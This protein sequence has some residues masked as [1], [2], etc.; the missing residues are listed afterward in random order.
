MGAIMVVPLVLA[1]AAN[2]RV[3]YS[4]MRAAGAGAVIVG[5]DRNIEEVDGLRRVVPWCQLSCNPRNIAFVH[6]DADIQV[7][8]IEEYADL[9]VLSGQFAVERIG[10]PKAGAGLRR[11]PELLIQHAVHSDASVGHAC[12]D[13]GA[14]T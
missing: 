10:L 11:R 14:L 7:L 9:G 3:E 5:I 13:N 12:G 6:A 1:W 4:L 2:P 8:A